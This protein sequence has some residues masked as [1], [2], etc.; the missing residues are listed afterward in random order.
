MS[1]K[2]IWPVGASKQCFIKH[3][4]SLHTECQRKKCVTV[5]SFVC[6]VF[7]PGGASHSLHKDRVNKISLDISKR[8][9]F[10]LRNAVFTFHSH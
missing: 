8:Q 6:L 4:N 9:L 3:G 10:G 7:H 2:Q 5:Q 1:C